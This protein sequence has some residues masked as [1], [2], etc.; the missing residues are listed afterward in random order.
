MTWSLLRTNPHQQR[1]THITKTI[2]AITS[3]E[4]QQPMNWKFLV[5]PA[6]PAFMRRS[7]RRAT[8]LSAPKSISMMHPTAL[9]AISAAGL[10]F[11]SGSPS[12]SQKFASKR[13]AKRRSLRFRVRPAN[14]SA[15]SLLNLNNLKLKNPLNPAYPV[16]YRLFQFVAQS[17]LKRP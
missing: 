17:P 9:M 12:A 11:I 6:Q 13:P 1:K 10:T 16:P 3:G 15:A 2:D 5:L 7:Q 8:I 4:R 14:N